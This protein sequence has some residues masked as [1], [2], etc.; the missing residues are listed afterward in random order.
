MLGDTKNWA[1]VVTSHHKSSINN[2]LR[3]FECFMLY[4]A[5]DTFRDQ[6]F[7]LVLQGCSSPVVVKFAD[8]QKEKEAKKLQQINQNLWNISAGGVTGFSPQYITVSIW[9]FWGGGGIEHF[10]ILPL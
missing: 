5:D 6:G 3:S 10:V 7:N 1:I 2:K 8:T 9:Q 4:L